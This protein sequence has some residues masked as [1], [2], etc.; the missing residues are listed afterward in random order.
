[1]NKIIKNFIIYNLIFVYKILSI[2]YDKCDLIVDSAICINNNEKIILP[3]AIRSDYLLKYLVSTMVLVSYIISIIGL[4]SVTVE[5][6][7]TKIAPKGANDTFSTPG[8]GA[9]GRILYMKFDEIY[10]V[11]SSGYGNHGIGII[12]GH[13]GFGGIGTSAYFRNNFIYINNHNLNN[14]NNHLN[15][16]FNNLNGKFNELIGNFNGNTL[17]GIGNGI[18]I[19]NGNLIEN[20]FTIMFYIYMLTDEKS[21]QNSLKFNQFCTI[22]HKVILN[23]LLLNYLLTIVIN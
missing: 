20:D 22:L 15:G 17:N 10:P 3:D 8:K 18:G 1:M 5:N 19:G 21:L 4:D 13:S 11:D 6:K 23:S 16:K 14:N 2:N 9:N 7:T 12:S